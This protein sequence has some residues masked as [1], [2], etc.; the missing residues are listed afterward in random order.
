[1]LIR[2]FCT[3]ETKYNLLEKEGFK[4]SFLYFHKTDS[5]TI[6]INSVSFG[7]FDS[8]IVSRNVLYLIM[9]HILVRFAA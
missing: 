6:T 1:M 8:L 9:P 7:N 5:D 4:P 2:V 3:R